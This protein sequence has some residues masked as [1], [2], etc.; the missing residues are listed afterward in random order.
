MCI[1][2]GITFPSCPHGIRIWW[3]CPTYT[4]PAPGESPACP[5]LEDRRTHTDV[6]PCARCSDAD[7]DTQDGRHPR[8]AS[9]APEHPDDVAC[10]AETFDET[11][12]RARLG[13]V[14]SE[15]RM[16][17]EGTTL[18]EENRRSRDSKYA[19]AWL[20]RERALLTAREDGQ[21]ESSESEEDHCSCE[22]ECSC[23]DDFSCESGSGYTCGDDC[24]CEDEDE[25][26]DGDENKDGDEGVLLLIQR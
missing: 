12:E 15:E 20:R 26:E 14:A 3:R 8:R 10:R 22:D 1:L 5:Q 13:R 24:S 11:L 2:T 16:C 17:R 21:G 25:D 19:L 7:P 18:E 9:L 23:A 4:A 6:L